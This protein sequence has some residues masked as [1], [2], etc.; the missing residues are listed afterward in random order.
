MI[1]RVLFL[2]FNVDEIPTYKSKPDLKDCEYVL[3]YFCETLLRG[4]NYTFSRDGF[5]FTMQTFCKDRL[6]DL[7]TDVVFDVLYANNII[8]K[9]L[10]L[11][12]FK[13]TYWILYFAAQRMHHDQDFSAFIFE[14]MRYVRYPEIIEFYTGIDRR[15]ED[16]LNHLIK[17]ISSTV[18]SVRDRCGLPE[19]LNPYGLARWESSP[20]VELRMQEEIANGVKESNLPAAIKDQYADSFYEKSRP[21]SQR[22]S[23][24]ISDRSF[25]CMLQAM[26][27]GARALRNS[28][29]VSL[30]AR[31]KLLSEILNCWELASMVLLLVLPALA[32]E[33]Y[34][35]FDGT[36]FRLVGDF[37]DTASKRAI[38]ILC[39]IPSNIVRLCKDDIYSQKMAPLL[40]DQLGRSRIGQVS[41]HELILLLIAKRPRKWSEHV[42]KYIVDCQKNSFYLRDVYVSLRSQYSYGFASP[43]VLKEIENLII[44]TAAKHVTGKSDPSP[45][46]IK[47]I[48]FSSEIIPKR[49]VF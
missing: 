5:R 26:H 34:A 24:V 41:K 18:N 8:I 42:H 1:K 13:S 7:E 2:L 17:D 44:I 6:I 22:L 16:A 47:K 4:S 3:G 12:S 46:S 32:K 28:D 33:G 14:D 38:R 29:Y 25:Y 48:R 40:F 11:F 20:E 10:T 45:K 49:E 35:S 37:G 9:H 23:D 36:N 39:E 15:R 19:E 30:D 31:R 27:S 43:Q 21:Y